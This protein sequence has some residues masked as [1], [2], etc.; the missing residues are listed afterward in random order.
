M[1]RD[2]LRFL[3]NVFERGKQY[4]KSRSQIK[5]EEKIMSFFISLSI[6]LKFLEN[7]ISFQ[8]RNIA[9]GHL[10][11][12]YICFRE[13]EIISKV[14]KSNRARVWEFALKTLFLSLNMNFSVLVN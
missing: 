14:M 8:S 10:G 1:Y 3:R 13:G 5:K 2:V 6:N 9:K 11:M 4:T 12:A 7:Y